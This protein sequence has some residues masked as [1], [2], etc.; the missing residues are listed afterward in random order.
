MKFPLYLPQIENPANNNLSILA[1]DVGGTKTN[2]AQFVS[3]NGKMV[4]QLEETYTTN[5]HNSLTEI[6][7]DFIKKNNFEKPDRISIGAAGPVVNGTCHTTNIKFKIDVTELSRDL[8]IDKVYLINDLEATAFGMTEMDDEFMVTMRN[9]NPSIGGHIAILAPGTGLGEA[10]LFWDGKY[11]RPMP[12]EGGH[13]EFAPR[14]D[15]EFELVK[16]LQKTYGEIIVWERL[17]SGPAIY[18]IYEFLRDVKGYE[19]QA[20]LTQKLAEAKD[21]S[22]VISETAMSGLCTT[23][24]LAMEMLVDFMARRANNMVLNYKATG[25]LILAGGIPPRIYNFINKD[26]IE[27]SFLKCDEMEPLLAGIPIYLNLNSKTALYGAAYYGA[28]SE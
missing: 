14:T 1:A 9:G 16:F 12:S 3:Q 10:C 15:V 19:E 23:C 25:G 7:L 22:A 27:E 11:L 6:I 18:K 26:K 8:Q 4:L 24:V 5:H 13:S 20:W 21:K 2:I 28:F 17:V